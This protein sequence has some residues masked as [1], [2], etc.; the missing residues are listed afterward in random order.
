MTEGEVTTHRVSNEE[1][2]INTR[3]ERALIFWDICS[4]HYLNKLMK[5]QVIGKTEG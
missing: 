2:N 1:V 3:T 5:G 4:N